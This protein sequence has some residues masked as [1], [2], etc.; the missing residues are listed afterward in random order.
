MDSA[1]DPQDS[2]YFVILTKMSACQTS[3]S[4]AISRGDS[5]PP[6][7]YEPERDQRRTEPECIRGHEDRVGIW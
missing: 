6:A 4:R 7:E 3:P 5:L 2:Q 1:F